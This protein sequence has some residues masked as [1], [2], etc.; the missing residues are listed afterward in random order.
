[1][2]S[3]GEI[4]AANKYFPLFFQQQTL[5]IA[6]EGAIRSESDLIELLNEAKPPHQAKAPAAAVAHAAAQGSL[7]CLAVSI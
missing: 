5:K 4:L 1:L 2:G 7:H 6:L 3:K